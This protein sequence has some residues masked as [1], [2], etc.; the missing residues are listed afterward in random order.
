MQRNDVIKGLE[1]FSDPLE[2]LEEVAL[3]DRALSSVNIILLRLE[4]IS[5]A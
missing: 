4:R 2:V 3:K 1:H 5:V